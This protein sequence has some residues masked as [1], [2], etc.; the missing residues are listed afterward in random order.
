VAAERAARAYVASVRAQA[1]ARGGL[2]ERA[3][4]VLRAA[5]PHMDELDRR[6]LREQPSLCRLLDVP[7]L[8]GPGPLAGK[9]LRERLLLAALVAAAVAHALHL[10]FGL[11]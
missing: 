2:A 6:G 1:L 11:F 4:A 10:Y 5:V 7:L 9:L 3:A 8:R